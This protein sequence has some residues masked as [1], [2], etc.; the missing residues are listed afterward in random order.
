MTSSWDRVRS[1]RPF[2]S[3]NPVLLDAPYPGPG[4][5]QPAADLPTCPLSHPCRPP[6]NRLHGA[7]GAPQETCLRFTYSP[8]ASLPN[9]TTGAIESCL[10]SWA[11]DPSTTDPVVPEWDLV[12]GSSKLKE[13][14]T[15]IGGIHFL[16]LNYRFGHKPILA[17]SYL[18]LAASGSS[19]VFCP[20]LHLYLAFRPLSGCAELCVA[21]VPIQMQAITS[22]LTGHFYTGG[23]FIL[24]G[25]AYVI[26]QWRW[27]QLTV[28]IPFF[29]FFLLSWPPPSVTWAKVRM[30]DGPVWEFSKALKI[31]RQVAALD[32]KKEEGEKLTMEELKL[33]LQKEISMAKAKYSITPVWLLVPINPSLPLGFSTGFTYY[34][35]AMSVAEFGVNLYFLQLISGG[36]DFLAK[37]INI[38]SI[39]HLGPPCFLPAADL[40]TLRTVL[41]VFGKRQ[42]SSSFSCLFLYSS[43]LLPIPA[44]NSPRQTGMSISNLWT[45]VGS[46]MAPL[47]KI[48]GEWQLFIP[49]VI[50][51]SIALPGG[52]AA[53]FLPETLHRPLPENIEDV[54]A[55][56]GTKVGTR[57]G[58]KASQRIP[59]Q[60][61]GPAWTPAEGNK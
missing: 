36:V 39:N 31:L 30:L 49:K 60:P 9:D 16:S 46:L 8:N 15:V 24:T 34:S 40:Q 56:K 44:L 5:P 35:L 43:E 14:G 18:L 59:L 41:A 33:S 19:A 11:Y 53:L 32:G 10:D 22:T 58:K 61:C 28:S 25:L 21:C 6:P 17:C 29:A 51:G 45:H 52:S 20:N 50:F 27:L 54:L 55:G 7:L 26:R 3:L 57:K 38:L 47:V 23:Q 1:R 48:T 37:F 2:Q 4:Q 12:C 42:L 13:V